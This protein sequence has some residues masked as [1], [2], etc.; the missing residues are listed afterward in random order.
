VV[1]MRMFTVAS[2]ALLPAAACSQSP[3]SNQS[4]DD[5]SV[6]E[7]NDASTAT[8]DAAANTPD[9]G[10]TTCRADAV[11]NYDGSATGS[12][13]GWRYLSDNRDRSWTPMT[14]GSA[15]GLSAF[16]GTGDP[17]PAVV[18]CRADPEATVCVDDA[19]SLLLL[20][21]ADADAA[22]EFTIADTGAF[23]VSGDVRAAAGGADQHLVIYRN[24]RE[25]V[26]IERVFDADAVVQSFSVD[27]EAIAGDRLLLTVF[28][29]SGVAVPVGVHLF[30]SESVGAFP[31]ACGLTVRFEDVSAPLFTED[32][33]RVTYT[34][35]IENVG[36]DLAAPALVSS[37]I[38]ELGQA[39]Q[40][41]RG[42]YLHPTAGAKMDYSGDFTI[43]MWARIPEVYSTWQDLFAD[44]SAD[45]D[46]G[47]VVAVSSSFTL[48]ASLLFPVGQIAELSF[49]WPA[50]GAWHFVRVVRR[51]SNE[52]FRV[53]LDGT[54]KASLAFDGT[55]DVSASERPFIAR[56]VE[57]SPPEFQGSLDDVRMF[58]RAYPCGPL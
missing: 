52:T 54:L 47:I 32:C 46:N 17:A 25:D 15:L 27:V 42:E 2:L 26:L 9:A 20:P 56:S 50:D 55:L 18:D 38:P 53:C 48:W 22:L 57:Y 3:F 16:V 51:T 39:I 37:V 49:S 6:S 8:A 29:D 36:T 58:A 4:G 1:L 24:T 31:R 7:P 23:T 41:T 43:Q 21:G 11:R 34:G 35:K 19:T 44:W 28:P 33:G 45:S 30:V 12:T 10:P 40:L 5:A 14:A 13:G